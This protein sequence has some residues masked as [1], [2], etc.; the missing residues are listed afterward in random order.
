MRVKPTDPNVVIRDPH[1]KTALPAEGGEVPENSFWI[2]R[3]RAGEIVRVDEPAQPVRNA[4]I[5]PLTTRE[6]K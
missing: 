3:L 2:R 5:A 6:G 4:P 1:T